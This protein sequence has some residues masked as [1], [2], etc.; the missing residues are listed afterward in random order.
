MDNGDYK[1]PSVYDLHGGAM[2]NNGCDDICF[3]HRPNRE[4]QPEDDLAIFK[5]S[6]IKK[7]II[8]GKPG[9]V[10]LNFDFKTNRFTEYGTS[11]LDQSHD[12]K[13]E[14]LKE[15]WEIRDEVLF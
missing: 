4:S 6:K 2:W 11:P 13:I 9:E 14:T 7:Q 12:K 15:E 1:M 3:I 5:S 8:C 10:S